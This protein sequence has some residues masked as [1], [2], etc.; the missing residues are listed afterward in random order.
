MNDEHF[1]IHDEALEKACMDE[2]INFNEDIED[3]YYRVNHMSEV[4]HE[5]MYKQVT[6]FVDGR[7]IPRFLKNV[8][9]G[10]YTNEFIY[11]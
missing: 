2:Y 9:K 7:E 11:D 1:Y 8:Y 5:V 10:T 3:A 6:G 4:N